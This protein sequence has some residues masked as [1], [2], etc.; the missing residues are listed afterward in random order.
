MARKTLTK[1]KK[2][3]PPFRGGKQPLVALRMS[4]ELTARID[5]WGAQHGIL[6][7]SEAL[8]RLAEKA[9]ACNESA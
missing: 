7:R 3:G 8:R 9:L 4:P 5:A 6:G 2:P 1:R